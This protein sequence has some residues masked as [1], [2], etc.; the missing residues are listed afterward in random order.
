MEISEQ[1]K[2]NYVNHVAHKNGNTLTWRRPNSRL[3]SVKYMIVDERILVVTGDLGH[4]MYMWSEPVTF[5]W[6]ASCDQGYFR[7]KC[8][9][10]EVGYGFYE[11]D[12]DKAIQTID[13]FASDNKDV[14]SLLIRR[15]K[16]HCGNRSDWEQFLHDEGFEL[17]GDN[18]YDYYDIGQTT[19]LRCRY[20]LAG[21]RMAIAQLSSVK[22]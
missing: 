21:L 1:I 20:H 19:H 4:A 7:S 8:T 3:Y 15:A 14:D 16:N 22:V 17:F 2:S 11:W 12:E 13:Y 10:S 5:E 6:L 18:E 9:A